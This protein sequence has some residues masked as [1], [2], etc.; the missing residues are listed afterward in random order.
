MKIS[1]RLIKRFREAHRRR[2]GE[3]ISQKGAERDLSML[4]NLVSIVMLTDKNLK[5]DQNE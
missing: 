1:N 5:G 2:F 4:A 3:N